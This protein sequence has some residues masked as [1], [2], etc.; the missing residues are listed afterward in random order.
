MTRQKLAH[1]R[2]TFHVRSKRVRDAAYLNPATTCWRCH[3][4]L[5][6]CGPRGDGRHRNGTRAWWE[7]G[8]LIDGDQTSPLAAECSPCNR[9]HGARHGNAL[10]G[11]RRAAQKAAVAVQRH[12]STRW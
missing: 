4:M 8:H 11:A 9:S 1:H 2:G 6:E 10:R 3:R 5:H 12:T 7:A